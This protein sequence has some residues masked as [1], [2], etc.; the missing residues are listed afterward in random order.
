M[1]AYS[2]TL[3]VPARLARWL[4]R[5]LAAHRRAIRTPRGSRAIGPFRQAVLVLRWFREGSRVHHLARD[6]GISQATAYRYLHEGIDVLAAQAPELHDALTQAREAG[7]PYVILDGTLISCD[8]VSV[9]TDKGTHLWFSGKGR[10]FAGNIQFVATPDGTPLWVSEVTP[11]SAHD[12][13]AARLH[14]FG[15]LYK[16]ARDGLP[17]LADL[18]YISAGAGVHTPLRPHPDIASPLHVDNRAHNRL[19]RGLRAPGERAAAELKQ[20]WHALRHVTLSPHRIGAITQAALALNNTWR[21][22]H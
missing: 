15:A 1:I 19:Q 6:T 12:L 22:I 10:R 8:R 4:A 16:A 18:A 17:T 14:A 21:D 3:D 7:L 13:T 9:I 11:G 2:A 5:L 20:R